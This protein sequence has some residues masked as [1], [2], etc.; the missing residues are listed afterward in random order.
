MSLNIEPNIDDISA[1]EPVPKTSM[2]QGLWNYIKEDA[3]HMPLVN[4]FYSN[5][6][7]LENIFSPGKFMSHNEWKSSPYYK[8]GMGD[9]FPDGVSESVARLKLN[10]F[11]SE[12]TRGNIINNMKGSGVTWPVKRVIDGVT[13][14]SDPLNIVGLM[15]VPEM[16]GV[17]RALLAPEM[18]EASTATR[19]AVA[20]GRGAAEGAALMVPQVLSEAHSN[21]AEGV[22]PDTLQSLYTIGL[23]AAIGGTIHGLLGSRKII[24]QEASNGVN[25]V[26]AAQMANDIK[27]DVSSVIKTGYNEAED[28][29]KPN[30]LKVSESADA[31]DKEGAL[32]P[33]EDVPDKVSE[34]E[35]TI[36]ES[37]D[38]APITREP[39]LNAASKI[40]KDVYPY[41]RNPEVHAL[42]ARAMRESPKVANTPESI[43][44]SFEGIDDPMRDSA[45]NSDKQAELEKHLNSIDDTALPGYDEVAQQIKNMQEQ[46]LLSPEDKQSFADIDD[47]EE[48]EKTIQNAL[49]AYQD[50]MEGFV[51]V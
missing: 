13:F 3:R 27:P 31:L 5:R 4:E 8:Q 28:A 6:A 47:E 20:A 16:I 44:N 50:C 17:K 26:A 34:S 1:L 14:L 30:D 29:F 9:A 33:I 11:N 24:T 15:T 12:V 51:N 39:E 32:K 18:L 46:D 48:S 10:D 41:V 43:A 40:I 37:E 2:H 21:I 25:Q 49:R 22:K 36:P 42:V 35:K 45:I 38:I 7:D 19:A 23:G